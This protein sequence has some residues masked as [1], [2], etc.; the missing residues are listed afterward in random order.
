MGSHPQSVTEAALL[1]E[2]EGAPQVQSVGLGVTEAALDVFSN[3]M[4][5]I[6]TKYVP[7]SEATLNVQPNNPAPWRSKR[8]ATRQEGEAPCPLTLPAPPQQAVRSRALVSCSDGLQLGL[9]LAPRS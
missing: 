3:F 1:G 9:I 2:I 7:I 6:A 5:H 4:Q 8:F